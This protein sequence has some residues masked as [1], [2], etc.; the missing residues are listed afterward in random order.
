MLECYI[1]W[2]PIRRDAAQIYHLSRDHHV[3]WLCM[4]G[5]WMYGTCFPG[6]TILSLFRYSSFNFSNKQ[7]PFKKYCC[8]IMGGKQRCD[9]LVVFTYIISVYHTVFQEQLDRQQFGKNCCGKYANTSP[10]LFLFLETSFSCYLIHSYVEQVTL[11]QAHRLHLGDMMMGKV[12]RYN[13]KWKIPLNHIFFKKVV[14]L[15]S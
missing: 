4:Y 9:R 13:K 14:S 7:Y 12:R 8:I 5:T 3:N 1:M 2:A 10:L 6:S 15:K 11:F